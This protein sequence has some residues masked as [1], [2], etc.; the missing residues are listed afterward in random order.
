MNWIAVAAAGIALFLA[1]IFARNK[2]IIGILIALI[3]YMIVVGVI[4]VGVN[5]SNMT[6]AFS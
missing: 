4:D 1:M 3:V 5:P 6:G 2:F